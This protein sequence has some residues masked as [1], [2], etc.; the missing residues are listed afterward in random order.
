MFKFHDLPIY[1][2]D[3]E[4]VLE[5]VSVWVRRKLHAYVCV[6]GAHGIVESARNKQVCVA[7]RRAGLIVPDGMPLVWTGRMM[8]F[9]RTERIYGPDLLLALC[10]RAE[11][12]KWSIFLYGT[13]SQT[14]DSLSRR[15]TIRF[16]SL[17]IVGQYAPP[18]R[19]LTRQEDYDV[20]R[21]INTS[22]AEIV[23]VG[24]STPKQELWMQNHTKKLHANA[25]VGV[26]AAFDF[27]A[28]TK[29]QAPRWIQRA[30]LEWLFRF[31]Q[32]PRRLWYRSVVMNAQ[33]VLLI[34]RFISGSK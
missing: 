14:L 11:V 25:L 30:G 12:K 24:L 8:G 13:S 29:K 22:R 28:G 23:F 3:M 26:G 2:G 15:L 16:P 27:I 34:V 20:T 6:T 19:S 18:F 5:V 33:F 9:H 7:H 31:F 32:E 10:A 21:R 4:G 17:R 1:S